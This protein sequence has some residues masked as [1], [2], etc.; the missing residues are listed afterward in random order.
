MFWVKYYDY[1]LSSLGLKV[2]ALGT[3]MASI[4]SF[5]AWLV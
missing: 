5:V 3:M 1:F 4:G 2:M